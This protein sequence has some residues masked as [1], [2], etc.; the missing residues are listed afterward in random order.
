[1]TLPRSA[2]RLTI[3]VP[4]MHHR[5]HVPDYVKIVERARRFRMA[6][7]T[8]LHGSRGFGRSSTVHRRRSLSVADDVPVAVLVVDTAERV[9]A[10]LDDIADMVPDA[11]VS[12]HP[13][14]VVIHRTG[15]EAGG[16]TR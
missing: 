12:R 13:V 1:M 10:F 16:P 9:D 11:V 7:A 5:G 8:V 15:S 3:Y 2:E 4:Q 6:G 14:Q